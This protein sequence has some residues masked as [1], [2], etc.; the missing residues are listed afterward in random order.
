MN[1]LKNIIFALFFLFFQQISTAQSQTVADLHK[2][3][4]DIAKK[5]LVKHQSLLHFFSIDAKGI[6]IYDSYAS[7]K[8]D[9]PECRIFWDELDEFKQIVLNEKEETQ[10]E[11]YENKKN[12]RFSEAVKNNFL[13]KYKAKKT[14]KTT[15]KKLSGY[16]IVLDPGHIAG[17]MEI[18]KIEGRFIEM[19]VDGKK[20]EFCEGDL[21]LSTA[22][23]IKE[24]LEK[25]GAEV[26]ISRPLPNISANG[27]TF[28]RW[29]KEDLPPILLSELKSKAISKKEYK[30]LQSFHARAFQT[31]FVGQDLEKRA[32]IINDFKAD[33]ALII[34]FNADATKKKWD[35]ISKNNYNMVFVPGAFLKEELGRP[36]DRLHFLR[37]LVLGNFDKSIR[38]AKLTIKEMTE[39][40]NVP[41]VPLKNNISYLKNAV[42]PISTGVYARN[43]G[44]CQML[45]CPL[46]YAE[47]FYQ[48]N[49]EEAKRLALNDSKNNKYAPRIVQLADAYYQ[50]ILLYFN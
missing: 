43:L 29:R 14:E 11:I 50:A 30:R 47:S 21:A 40:L 28:E 8:A 3:Y 35:D 20:L 9:L 18:A 16:R 48:D 1:F 36:L 27:K 7:K 10:L 17:D 26:L 42:I 25:Q 33:L 41:A 23:L 44:L 22:K 39:E 38:F 34:H 13:R 45:N 15:G 49:A 4:E 24:K 46:V 6:A 19:E 2:Y 12:Q 32:E 5:Y 37:L 31:Y